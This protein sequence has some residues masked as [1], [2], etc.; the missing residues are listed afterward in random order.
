MRQRF[1][2]WIQRGADEPARSTNRH[3]IGMTDALEVRMA[4]NALHRSPRVDRKLSEKVEV[5]PVVKNDVQCTVLL[6]GIG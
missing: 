6:I 4:S 5:V 2:A 3:A 1:V